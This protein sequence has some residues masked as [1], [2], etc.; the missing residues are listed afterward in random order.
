T[1]AEGFRLLVRL[2]LAAQEPEA[3]STGTVVPRELLISL[4]NRLPQSEETP[5]DVECLDA[6]VTGMR[7]GA[8]ATVVERAMLLPTG[9]GLSAGAFGTA[10]PIATMARWQ[11]SDRVAPGV[12]PPELAV[13]VEEFL[14]ALEKEGVILP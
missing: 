3:L 10:I 12:H 6:R 2:G 7:D 13:P 11:T 5:H 1:I 8:P 4:L 9:E 14:A